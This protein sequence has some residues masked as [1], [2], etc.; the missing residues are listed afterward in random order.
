VYRKFY[1]GKEARIP[2][3]SKLFHDAISGGTEITAEEY[4]RL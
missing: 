1:G 2:S 3:D 4:A